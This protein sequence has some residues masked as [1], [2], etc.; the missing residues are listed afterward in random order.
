MSDWM[1]KYN[2]VIFTI[3]ILAIIS[4]LVFN[5]KD[6]NRQIKE[7]KTEIRG[8]ELDIENKKNII[9]KYKV[10][11]EEIKKDLK[12]RVEFIEILEKEKEGLKE[13]IKELEGIKIISMEAT[14]YTDDEASQGK[15][16]GQTASGRKPA[17]GI[18]AVD[19]KVIPLGTKLYVEGYGNAVAGDT[20]GAIKGNRIDLFMATRGQ[21][22]KFGRKQVKVRIKE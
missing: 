11:I 20:G 22:L 17:V 13:K 21:A 16:V 8:L 9:E 12:G 10:E 6:R 3:Y 15:W 5:I 7:I 1:K 2:K 19:P 18:V 14:A 4:L